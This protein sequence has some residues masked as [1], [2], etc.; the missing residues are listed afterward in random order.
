MLNFRSGKKYYKANRYKIEN[1]ISL[2]PKFID[3]LCFRNYEY[4]MI[5]MKKLKKIVMVTVSLIRID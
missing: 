2:V 1:S 5:K 3:F 4:V